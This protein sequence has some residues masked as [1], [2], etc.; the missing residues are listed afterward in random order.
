MNLEPYEC[1]AFEDSEQGLVSSMGAG[2]KTIVTV[3]GYTKDQ[4]FDGAI[5]VLSDFGEPDFPY[6]VLAG[7]VYGNRLVDVGLLRKWG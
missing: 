2:L 7:E 5:A 3:N 4:V 6:E 1:I